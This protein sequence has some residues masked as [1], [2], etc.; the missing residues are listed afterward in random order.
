[1][2]RQAS[3]DSPKINETVD[4]FVAEALR[5]NA[6]IELHNHPQ[7]QHAFDML[8]AGDR[9]RAIIRRTLTFLREHLAGT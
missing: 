3:Q 2:V 4:R 6:P 1:M 7:G 5:A 8:D 9:S